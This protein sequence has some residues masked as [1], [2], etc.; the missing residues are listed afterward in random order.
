MKRTPGASTVASLYGGVTTTALTCRT[1][2]SSR[3]RHES[4]LDLPLPVRDVTTLHAALRSVCGH[5][6]LVGDNRLSCDVC[7]GRHDA[8]RSVRLGR[9][10]TETDSVTTSTTTSTTTTTTTTS[11]TTDAVQSIPP[12]LW[13]PL[14]RFDYDRERGARVKLTSSFLVIQTNML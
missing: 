13:L 4:I 14:S 1:C 8:T 3:Y 6:E 7:G 5:E 11:T 2:K 10:H 12:L 9:R